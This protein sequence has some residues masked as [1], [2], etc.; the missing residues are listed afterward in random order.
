[1]R[2]LMVA[3]ALGFGLLLVA[4]R[5]EERAAPDAVYRAYYAK[6]AEGRSFEEDAGYHAA[7]RRAEVQA[8]LKAQ[9]EAT[10]RSSEDIEALYLNFTQQLAKCGALDLA[11]EQVDGDSARL[12]YAVTDTCDGAQGGELVVDMVYEDGWKILSDELNVSAN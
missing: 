4:C 8:Q 5:E 6:V 9:A 7:A 2:F 11:G 3:M 10:S 1:M 12:V